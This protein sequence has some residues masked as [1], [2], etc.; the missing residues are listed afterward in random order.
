MALAISGH[1]LIQ[2]PGQSETAWQRVTVTGWY[3]QGERRE[4]ALQALVRQ[5]RKSVTLFVD[6]AHEVR[7]LLQGR[8]EASRAR[9]MT[10]QMMA[11]GLPV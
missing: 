4:R 10:E 1:G 6:Q 7:L 11:A 9:E 5:G 3:G 2:T 8:L